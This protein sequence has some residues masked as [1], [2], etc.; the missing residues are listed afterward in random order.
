MASVVTVLTPNGRRMNVKVP[1]NKTVLQ[2][3]DEVC[4]KH[5]FQSSEYDLRHHKRI[6]DLSLMFRFTGLPNN[7]QL[8]MVKVLK[9]RQESEVVLMI[10]F[11]DGSRKSDS[12]QPDLT[13]MD[14]LRKLCPEKCSEDDLVLIYMRTDIHGTALAT[15]TLKSLG[16]TGG[17]AMFRLVQRKADSLKTQ[18]NVSRVISVAPAAQPA[19]NSTATE[20]TPALD[21]SGKT[22]VT[23][24]TSDNATIMPG[25]GHSLSPVSNDVKR[26]KYDE[27]VATEAPSTSC[28]DVASEVES[29][30]M[31]VEEEPEIIE[32]GER[33]AILFS[34]DSTQRIISD[35][36]AKDSFFDVTVNDIK[37]LLRDL[38]TQ[39]QGLENAPLMTT[40]MREM[41]HDNQTMLKLNRYRTTVIRIQF[42]NRLVLQGIF[43]PSD[44]VQQVVDFVRGF[45]VDPTMKFHLYITP[46]KTVLDNESRL[47]ENHCV[48]MALLH[49]GTDESS[50]SP[51][52]LREEFLAKISTHKAAVWSAK[53][54]R[55]LNF[56]STT[57]EDGESSSNESSNTNRKQQSAGSGTFITSSAISNTGTKV[58]KWFKPTG[59]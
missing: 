9:Q 54:S 33:H 50:C 18:A 44:T 2:I 20:N 49:F 47:V 39:T 48:P 32:I 5:N 51:N 56:G 29:N 22:D 43:L 3:L 53:K 27:T 13:L 17:R 26:A 21:L 23:M 52:L 25:I 16:L 12:F 11:E 31:E 55:G 34:L 42:A 58:P 46:P 36:D 6:L 14:V 40:K 19:D 8:E 4:Q 1:P 7:A 30:E 57:S 24:E 38:R 10:Q 37:V 28:P 59:K 41:E 35:E 45:L 15:T